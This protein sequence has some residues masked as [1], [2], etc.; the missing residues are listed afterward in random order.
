MKRYLLASVLF[1]IVASVLLSAC[2]SGAGT[3]SANLLSPQSTQVSAAK[4]DLVKALTSVQQAEARGASNATLSPLINQLN[5][6]LEYEQK[7]NLL[8][9]QGNT[10]LSNTY[11]NESI[12]LSNQISARARV[13]GNEAETASDYRILSSYILAISAAIILSVLLME[14]SR[15][16]AWF[17]RRIKSMIAT[18]SQKYSRN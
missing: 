9:Q 15:F 6:A 2:T 7:S 4:A 12:A 14:Y 1:L 11:A 3:D 16:R 5:Q 13:I 17:E 10:D 8:L 18:N